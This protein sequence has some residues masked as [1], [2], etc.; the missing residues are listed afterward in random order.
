MHA[1]RIASIDLGSNTVRLLI[2]RKRKQ[3]DF[4]PILREKVITR[5]GGNFSPGKKLD[6]GAILKTLESLVLFKEKINKEGVENVFAVATGVLREAKNAGIFLGKIKKHTG[7]S[8]RLLSGEEEACLMLRGVLWSLKNKGRTY[9]VVDI[10]GWSTEILWVEGTILKKSRSLR[11]GTVALCEK[12]LKTDPPLPIEL[13]LMELYLKKV[14]KELRKG[15]ERE[16]LIVQKLNSTLV[17]TAGTMTTLAAIDQRLMAYDSQKIQGH[18]ISHNDLEK[19]Y[20]SLC[21]IPFRNRGKIP[22]VEKGREDLIIAGSAIA[23][24]ILEVFGLKKIKVVDSGLLEGV[25]L[26]GLLQLS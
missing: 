11:L 16:G 4:K 2:A 18:Q 8:I 7:F 13:N 21:A 1:P 6:E 26:G 10:G 23:L 25:L 17:G 3:L 14:L 9:M 5:L 22:G 24:K 12:Y 19:I 20:Q 15:F